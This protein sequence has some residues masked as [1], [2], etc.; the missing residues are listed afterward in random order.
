MNGLII[1]KRVGIGAVITSIA[2]ALALFFPGYGAAIIGM[3]VPITFG[4][5]IWWVNKYGVTT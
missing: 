1:G 3:A 4:I 5:Q 2:G